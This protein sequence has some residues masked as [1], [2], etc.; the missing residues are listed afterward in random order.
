MECFIQ[1][2]KDIAA[3]KLRALEQVVGQPLHANQ[4]VV[5]RVVDVGMEASDQ[6]RKDALA[7][8]AAIARRG[9]AN[10]AAQGVSDQEVEAAIDEAVRHVRRQQRNG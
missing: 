9:R 8:A 3:D 1:N 10:A 4:Q 5:I 2:V 6:T 7:R